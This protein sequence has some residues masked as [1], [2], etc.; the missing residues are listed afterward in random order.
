MSQGPAYNALETGTY[1]PSLP[2]ACRIARL[3][4]LR[5]EEVFE[6]DA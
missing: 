5:S 1:D 4:A 2:L 3:F 6:P